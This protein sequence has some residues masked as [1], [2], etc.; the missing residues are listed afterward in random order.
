MYLP[1][2]L[3]K[4]DR[5]VESLKFA[6][7]RNITAIVLLFVLVI[8]LIRLLLGV[9]NESFHA[10]ETWGPFLNKYDDKIF[11]QMGL[12]YVSWCHRIL[13]FPLH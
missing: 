12:V 3:T 5:G 4:V 1:T 10:P 11:E 8:Q 6:M 7:A 9:V 13:V 2:R